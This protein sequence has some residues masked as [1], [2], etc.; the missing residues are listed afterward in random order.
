MEIA[1]VLFLDVVGYSEAADERDGARP[2][3]Q[4]SVASVSWRRRL[5]TFPR[6]VGTHTS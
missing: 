5:R 6:S 2:L 1:H 3:M 4:I